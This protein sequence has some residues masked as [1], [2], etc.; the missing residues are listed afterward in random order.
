MNLRDDDEV[1]PMADV[2][3]FAAIYGRDHANKRKAR[4]VIDMWSF[5]TAW[6]EEAFEDAVR[7]AR[8]MIARDK[9]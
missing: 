1:W 6:G 3:K 7:Q 4:M 2:R 9:S 8:E 5:S